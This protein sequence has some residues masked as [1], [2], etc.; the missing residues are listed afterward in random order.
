MIQNELLQKYT[1]LRGRRDSNNTSIANKS[2]NFLD[3]AKNKKGRVAP[4]KDVFTT[5]ISLL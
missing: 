5:E 2:Y 1:A 3:W 4:P